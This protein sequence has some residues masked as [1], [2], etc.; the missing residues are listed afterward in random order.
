[1]NTEFQKRGNGIDYQ[2]AH[3]EHD[4]E[5]DDDN[6]DDDDDDDDDVMM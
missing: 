4:H 6:H 3:H 5:H 1:M 2:N